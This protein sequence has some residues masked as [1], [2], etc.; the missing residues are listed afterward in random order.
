MSNCSYI[1]QSVY[2]TCAIDPYVGIPI[3]I[4]E[5]H[6]NM[7]HPENHNIIPINLKYQLYEIFNGIQKCQ[8]K[9]KELLCFLISDQTNRIE[10]YIEQNR[11]KYSQEKIDEVKLILDFIEKLTRDITPSTYKNQKTG[12]MLKSIKK[13]MH[14]TND[15]FKNIIKNKT[16]AYVPHPNSKAEYIPGILN[17]NFNK[18]NKVNQKYIKSI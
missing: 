14:D 5:I 3:L 6:F 12:T 11:H 4:K 18:K 15:D 7:D 17:N 8:I 2:D 13:I 1:S 10:I 9:E 16:I